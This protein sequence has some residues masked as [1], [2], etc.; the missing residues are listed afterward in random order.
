[1]CQPPLTKDHPPLLGYRNT[2][3][4]EEFADAGHGTYIK[5]GHVQRSGER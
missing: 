1:M 4:T 2:F 5:L 3:Q